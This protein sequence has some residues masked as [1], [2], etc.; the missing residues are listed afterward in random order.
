MQDLHPIT[1]L[2]MIPVGGRLLFGSPVRGDISQAI[3]RQAV[4]GGN[5]RYP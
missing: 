5:Q 4:N 1:T 2:G 3:T